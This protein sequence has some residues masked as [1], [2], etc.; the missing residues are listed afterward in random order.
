[1]SF[2]INFKTYTIVKPII[3]DNLNNQLKSIKL[4]FS[5]YI[6]NSLQIIANSSN[7]MFLDI[8]P[9]SKL[10]ILPGDNTTYYIPHIRELALVLIS[11]TD[12]IESNQ[13]NILEKIKIYTFLDI[14]NYNTLMNTF[15]EIYNQW[16][17]P[18]LVAHNGNNF[19]FIILKA[20]CHRYLPTE[21]T[22][23]LKF[24]FIDTLIDCFKAKY[25]GILKIQTL[26]N[27]NLFKH[28]INSSDEL[29][30]KLHTAEADTLLLLK[31]YKQHL[32]L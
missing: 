3:L 17:A 18:T 16:N 19:D 5:K 9:T 14:K 26:T 13:T 25:S 24:K 29:L 28:Y 32:K 2:S 31:W 7:L 20:H 27:S 11:T 12:F 1:M 8:E 22:K 30:S 6:Q 15:L 23:K 4:N 21:K 10:G